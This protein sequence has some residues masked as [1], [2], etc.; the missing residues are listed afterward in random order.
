MAL[1][2]LC[3]HPC[4]IFT[5]ATPAAE[6]SA[7]TVRALLSYLTSRLAPARPIRSRHAVRKST[8]LML[9]GHFSTITNL[10]QRLHTPRTSTS[11]LPRRYRTRT[12]LSATENTPSPTPPCIP[13]SRT[14]HCA[15]VLNM[16]AQWYT[17]CSQPKVHGDRTRAPRANATALLAA[18]YVLARCHG[19]SPIAK[20]SSNNHR[21][22]R[23][24]RL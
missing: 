19:G 11:A 5:S 3:Q 8:H 4:G 14:P 21:Q 24:L 16:K 17:K 2:H 20:P 7:T 13:P 6:H 23:E 18:H 12:F 1:Q 9:Y 10:H 15:S 22:Q